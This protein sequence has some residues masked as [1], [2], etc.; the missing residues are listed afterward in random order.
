MD[1]SYV[2]CVPNCFSRPGGA[3]HDTKHQKQDLFFIPKS[4]EFVEQQEFG[5]YVLR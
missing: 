1:L 5:D 4:L 2:A 3:D